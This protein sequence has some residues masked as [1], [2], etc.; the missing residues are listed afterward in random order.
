MIKTVIIDD[1]QHSIDTLVWKLN[2]YCED[3]DIVAT[4][5]NPVQGIKYLKEEAPDLLFLDIEMPMMNGFDVLEELGPVINFSVIFV[6]AYDSFGIKAVKFSALDYILK[7]VHNKELVGAVQKF[8]AVNKQ[9]SIVR[10]DNLLSNI[11]AERQRKPVKIALASRESIE[12]VAPDDIILCEADSNYSKV[13][14]INGKMRLISKTLRDF[15]EMLEPQGFF[16]PHNSFVINL[17]Y[18]QEFQRLDGGYLVMKNK[19]KV[20]VSKQKRSQVL[21]LLGG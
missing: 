5:T 1:E 8:K 21:G 20:P 6:T 7:P 2:N 18:V 15:E 17:E 19:M 3:V 9:D 11:Q 4:F 13:F 14:L 12:F 10:I 16:R